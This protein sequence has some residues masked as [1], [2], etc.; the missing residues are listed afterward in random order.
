MALVF[1]GGVAA[2]LLCKFIADGVLR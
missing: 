2:F 1:F